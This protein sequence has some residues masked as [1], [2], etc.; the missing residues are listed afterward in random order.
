MGVQVAIP[1][2][3]GLINDI[4]IPLLHAAGIWSLQL[5]R[6]KKFGAYFALS[7]GIFACAVD[8]VRND[9][10]SNVEK[11]GEITWTKAGSLI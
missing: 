9:S 5:A 1:L 4:A 2:V 11:S 7:R 8:I 6:V 3:A 10:F